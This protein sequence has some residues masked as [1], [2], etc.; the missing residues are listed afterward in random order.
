MVTINDN[1]DPNKQPNFYDGQQLDVDD[2]EQAQVYSNEN[3]EAI[4]RNIASDGIVE[5]LRVEMDS[6]MVEPFTFP[7]I[8]QSSANPNL[9]NFRD[10]P[11]DILDTAEVKMY[12]VFKAETNNLQRFDLKVQLLEGTGNSTLVVE[13]LQ[14][15]VPSNPQSALGDSLFVKQFLAEEIPSS[16]SD[17]RLVLDLSSND[18]NQG[19][20]LTV[21]NHYAIQL[22]FIRETNSQDRLRVYH[23]NTTETASFLDDNPNLGAFFF[24]NNNFQQGLFNENAEL[25]QLILYH[26]VYTSAVLVEPGEAYFNGE[27][28]KVSTTQRF[29]GL[30]DR[31]NTT[32]EDEFINYVA[33]KYV[34]DTTD[35]ETH[36]R[37]GNPVDSRFEDSFEVDV[38]NEV[39]WGVAVGEGVWL[40]LATVT[41]RNV[42]PF[43]ERIE[44]EV[45]DLTNLAFNDWLNPC[46]TN[47]SLAALQIKTAR[48]DDFIFYV[49]N[50]PG[51]VPLLDDDGTQ[52]FDTTGAAIVDRIVRIFLILYLD[53]GTNERRFEMALNTTS[54]TSP[55]FSSY[56]IAITDPEE[57]LISVS[58]FQFDKNELAPN[59]F[60]NYVAETERG[61]SI[62]IQ[63]FNTQVRA[64]D[65]TT[66]ILSL[67]RERQFEVRLNAGSLTAV[68]NEDLKLGAPIVPF[69][70]VGQKVTGFESVI[71]VD[72][73][74]G[75][76]GTVASST[77]TPITDTLLEASDFKFE[78]LPM[79]F[80]LGGL[81][82]DSET[83]VTAA[84]N[85]ED[86]VI[87]VNGT[88]IM[89]SG[90]EGADRGGTGAPHTVSGRVLF[91]DDAGERLTQMQDLAA[92]LGLPAPADEDD[93]ANF[94]GLRVTTRDVNGR[95]NSQQ[96]LAAVTKL[97]TEGNLVYRVIAMGKGVSSDAGFSTGEEGFLYL[98]NRQC[99]D[100]VGVPLQFIYTP[101]GASILDVRVVDTQEQWFGERTIVFATSSTGLAADEVGVHPSIGQVF[102]NDHDKTL[103][104][105]ELMLAT[106]IEYFQL[107]EVF[108]VVNFYETR[109]I[110]WGE[111]NDCPI[112]NEDVSIQAAVAAG[113]IVIKVNGST[114]F[115][116]GG[117]PVDLTDSNIYTA[118]PPGQPEPDQS[119]L[120]PDR[121]ALD[122]NL[123]RIVFGDNIKPDPALTV[124]ITYY[125][126]R[127]ITTCA[128]SALG[129]TYDFRFDFN[130]DGRVDEAD[131]QLFLASFGSQDGDPNYSTQYDFNNDGAVDSTD[132]QEFLDHFGTVVSGDPSFEEATQSR[133]NSILVFRA[134]DPIR[135]FEVVRALSEASS[136][137]F[138][139][140]R[141]VLFFNGDVPIRV[142]DD[143]TILFGYAVT[144]VTGINSV[145]VTTTTQAI[146]S[147]VNK[148]VVEIF[149][150]DD[151][152]DTRTAIDVLVETR[153]LEGGAEVFDNT[154]TFSPS[155]TEDGTY[156]FRSLWKDE[157]VAVINKGDSLIR[158]VF[159]EEKARSR[160]GPFKMAYNS[161]DFASD[162]SSLTI[163]FA[164]NP[165]STFA[166]GAHDPSGLHLDGV[167]IEDMRFSILLLVPVNDN[168]TNIWRWH[169]FQAL[170]EDQGIKLEFNDHLAL[171]S[172]FRGKNGVPVLQ[173]FG[174]ETN[175]V[176]LRPQF[177][178][179]DVENDLGN[180]IVVRDDIFARTPVLHNHTSDE[181]GG[182]LESGNINFTDPEA[183]FETG[184]V[185]E[186]VYQLQDLLQDQINDLTAQFADLQVNAEDVIVDTTQGS[187]S[188]L[189]APSGKIAL[190]DALVQIIDRISWDALNDCP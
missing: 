153:T 47:P 49:D 86:I 56:F 94:V 41:D 127:P 4:V 158:P 30:A 67:T 88:S 132:Y 120:D 176:D 22:R 161:D 16:T 172:R 19:I 103:I 84:A 180:I 38:F 40:L 168:K 70:A 100:I 5:G 8:P 25:I 119:L 151:N 147:Q 77:I 72:E 146:T 28:I 79:S 39:E 121:I 110:P 130:L 65:P 23:S 6:T 177:A 141:T 159:Y 73:T 181:Q 37:T 165:E 102:W 69:G 135:Q 82:E 174:V 154:I 98:E 81:I 99:K 87:K 118:M 59:T 76:N 31:R 178:G 179:G 163:R 113:D 136:V 55:P 139:L 149:N 129:Q 185:T 3:D 101:F 54:S 145:V 114:T 9:Q 188:C 43:S 36:P 71:Q 61:R 2:L 125:H 12:Q 48:P 183:R 83:S 75:R 182:I 91:S 85:A 80:E 24:V 26:K 46:V 74:P 143:Y 50:V 187:L 184:S 138:P 104:F 97:D 186:V 34:L 142:T 78:P 148:D 126:L 13:L 21:G 15:S 93:F 63:D 92:S 189:D 45:S 124:Q 53:G 58:D 140:G 115:D 18:S 173:P 190:S 95:D 1:L 89:W 105:D 166:D 150:E 175:Q 27:H 14:L 42:V 62:F 90:S 35:S 137:Q 169:N 32:D 7:T 10:F 171:D 170:P 157:G 122:P 123:G 134:D 111:A 52:I 160:L 51:E 29:L 152:T 68:I 11:E 17:G 60:Y 66:G 57:E 117:G 107:D 128:T 116:P 44:F 156:I 96:T 109:L 162:G 167:P 144:L 33:V 133:L 155:I 112:L 164:T 108:A 64:P 20:T 131:L 106:T